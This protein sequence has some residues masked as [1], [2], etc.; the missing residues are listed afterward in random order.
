MAAKERTERKKSGESPALL[1]RL[2]KLHLEDYL[3]SSILTLIN[4]IH[5]D[6]DLATVMDSIFK[7]EDPTRRAARIDEFYR[8]NEGKQNRMAGKMSIVIN[9]LLAAYDPFNNLSVVSLNDRK[10]QLEFLGI[11][12]RFD[13]E[14]A[15]VGQKIVQS[16]LLL[17]EGTRALGIEESARTLSYFWYFG[18]DRALWKQEH[19]VKRTDKNVTVTVPENANVDDNKDPGNGEKE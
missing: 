15:T 9:T 2:I 17:R 16:N 1:T 13:W 8:L 10:A 3:F 6:R 14:S 11:A 7:E 19:T 4:S 18:L 12:L 5:A